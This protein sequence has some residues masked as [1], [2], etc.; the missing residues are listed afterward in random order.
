MDRK[1][2]ED[3]YK[4]NC[5]TIFTDANDK[6]R[7]LVETALQVLKELD[8]HTEVSN[9]EPR[10]KINAILGDALYRKGDK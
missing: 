3:F 8:S 2:I 5:D 9:I 1:T 10:L 4:N 6:N 7:D